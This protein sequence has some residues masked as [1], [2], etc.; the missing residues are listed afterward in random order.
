M[1]RGTGGIQ[2]SPEKA[3]ERLLGGSHLNLD[4]QVMLI[5]GCLQGWATPLSRDGRGEPAE[6]RKEGYR[7]HGGEPLSRQVIGTT[8]TSSS[9]TTAAAD[10]ARPALDPEFSLWLMGFP[11]A[12]LDCAP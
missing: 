1:A 6:G 12:Y 3:L 2:R 5:T 11:G 9:A 4:D 8:S 10:D 7:W